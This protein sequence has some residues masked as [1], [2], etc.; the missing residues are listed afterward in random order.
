L[1][2]PLRRGM[3]GMLAIS[4]VKIKRRIADSITSDNREGSVNIFS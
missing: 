1:I 4:F 2:T 3:S